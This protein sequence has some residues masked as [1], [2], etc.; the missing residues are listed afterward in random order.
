MKNKTLL[1]I[2]GTLAA[3]YLL[4]RSQDNTV[5][6]TPTTVPSGTQPPQIETVLSRFQLT[7]NRRRF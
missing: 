1:I 3:A 4:K 5:I 6:V 7:G 2:A